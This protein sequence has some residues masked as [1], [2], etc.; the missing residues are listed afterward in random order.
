MKCGCQYLK[1]RLYLMMRCVG[2]M[3]FPFHHDYRDFPYSLYLLC[4]QY[5]DALLIP[6]QSV[7]SYHMCWSQ[8]LGSFCFLLGMQLGI[9]I[10]YN[11]RCTKKPLMLGPQKMMRRPPSFPMMYSCL[12]PLLSASYILCLSGDCASSC[13][14]LKSWGM[15]WGLGIASEIF[16]MIYPRIDEN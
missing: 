13:R 4:A 9:W 8:Y 6:T 5:V 16:H 7:L 14:C 3:Y 10:C 12:G 2:Q 1:W 15:S 11:L